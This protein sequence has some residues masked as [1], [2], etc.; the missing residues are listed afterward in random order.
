VS[1]SSSV[2][3]RRTTAEDLDY[4]IAQ[5]RDG[6]NSPYIRQWARDKHLGAINDPYYAHLIVERIDDSRP[7]GFVILIGVR[8]PEGNLEFKR[9]A[10]SEKGKGYGRRAVELIKQFAFEQT[11][12]HRLWLEVA[13]HNQRAFAVYR[14]AGFVIEGTH[15]ESA[16]MSGQRA[17]LTVMSMLRHEYQPDSG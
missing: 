11:D 14:E 12:C 2:R 15:R 8:E 17:S 6:E 16:I 4:V 1:D 7:V 9:I 10:V 5:E 3:L 13:E